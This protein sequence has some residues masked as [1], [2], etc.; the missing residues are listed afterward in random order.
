MTGEADI[1]KIN[2]QLLDNVPSYLEVPANAEVEPPVKTNL[3]SLPFEGLTWENFERLCLRLARLDSNVEYCQIYGKRGDKQGG[4]DLF[5]R[6]T[7]NSKYT[8]HQCKN[9]GKFS[10]SKIKKAVTK[11]LNGDWVTKSDTFILCMRDSLKD[12]ARADEI[13]SQTEVLKQEGITFIPRDQE[14]LSL[15]LKDYPEIVDD[16]FGRSWVKAFC[17]EEA[18]TKLGKRLDLVAIAKLRSKCL[19]LYKTV[20]HQQDPGLP[21]SLSSDQTVIPF[22][23]RYIIPDVYLEKKLFLEKGNTQLGNVTSMPDPS[24]QTSSELD[25]KFTSQEL[26]EYRQRKNVNAWLAKNAQNI[27]LGDPG[28]GKSSLLRLI[29]VDL[30]SDTPQII[31]VAQKWGNYLPIWIPFGLWTQ[32]IVEG[33]RAFKE[34]LKVWLQNWGEEDLFD[35]VDQAIEENKIILLIDGLDEWTNESAAANALDQLQVFITQHKVPV[36]ISSRPQGF[37]KLQFQK[38]EWNIGTLSDLTIEQQKKLCCIWFGNQIS[39]LNKENSYSEEEIYKKAAAEA[40]QFINELNNNFDLSNLAKNP[41]LLCLLLAIRFQ[42]AH[43]PEDRFKAYEQIVT[44]MIANHPEKRKKAALLLT[45][46][47]L[48]NEELKRT[49]AFLAYKIQLDFPQGSISETEAQDL[50]KQYLTNEQTGLGLEASTAKDYAKNILEFGES[51]SGLLVKKSPNT[52]GFFHRTFLEYLTAQ[53]LNS[54]SFNEQLKIVDKFCADPQWKEVFLCFFSLIT[55]Q[56]DIK[57]FIKAIRDKK[58]N[59]QESCQANLLVYEIALGN[60]NCPVGL[61]RELVDEALNEIQIKSWLPQ[62]DTLMNLILNGLNS[63]KVQQIY[64]HG[65]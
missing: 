37:A 21:L 22:E 12:K 13:V 31:S 49:Y 57:Q 60:F 59:L 50:V 53:H 28:S 29:A 3:Q 9:E 23:K 34:I 15:L 20:F 61:A 45:E 63:A 58:F 54:L 32:Q 33:K 56:D 26:V 17:G 44:H 18:A 25:S 11:F 51:N 47:K 7:G 43:L 6:K 62:R 41:L 39:S 24:Q 65:T 46:R 4:I 64:T 48:T 8:V 38:A 35:L 2:G 40:D 55:K 10:A 42:N 16:F 36:I 5:A 1:K 19:S 52:L 14:A 30:L 27:I